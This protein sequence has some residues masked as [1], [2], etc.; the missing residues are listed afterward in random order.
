M[1]LIFD[2]KQNIF[3]QFAF[4]EFYYTSFLSV[5]V[6]LVS[7]IPLQRSQP[8]QVVCSW[9]LYFVLPVFTGERRMVYCEV[10]C[11]LRY[12]NRVVHQVL[13]YKISSW[14]CFF[15]LKHKKASS[16]SC[17]LGFHRS[18]PQH[19]VAQASQPLGKVHHV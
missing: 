13:S 10:L 11:I 5:S 17:I 2:I 6:S 19:I 9:E 4:Y 8:I 3:T 16:I 12:V 18:Q 7:N 14:P 15:Y 1:N